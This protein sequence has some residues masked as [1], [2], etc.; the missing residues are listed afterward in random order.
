[1]IGPEG[2][3]ALDESEGFV[4]PPELMREHAGVVQRTR[5]IG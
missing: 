2:E 4:V 1:L 5:M 3:A